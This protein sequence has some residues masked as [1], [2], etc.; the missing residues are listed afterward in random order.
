[1]RVMRTPMVLVGLALLPA[2]LGATGVIVSPDVNARGGEGGGGNPAPEGGS[3]G[4]PGAT[5]GGGSGG[6]D[7][8]GGTTGGN[9]G[10]AG[11]G[12]SQTGTGGMMTP[13][14]DAGPR[15]DAAPIVAR[16]CNDLP[17]VGLWHEISPPV[18]KNPSNMETLAVVVS[19]QDQSVYAAAGNKTSG[20]NSGTGVYKSMDCGATWKLVSTGKNSDKLKSGDP[21]AMMIHPDNPQILYTNNGYG[22]DPTIY[23]STNGGVDWTALIPDPARGVQSFVQAIA[24]N[25]DDPEHIAITFHD[26]CKAPLNGLCLSY[27]TD[28]GASWHLFNGPSALSG[29][30]EA[31]TLSILGPTNYFFAAKG[32]W[33]TADTGKTWTKVSGDDF[34]ASYAGSTNLAPDGTLYVAGANSLYSSRSNPIGS[35]IT[36]VTNGVHASVVINDGVN[37]FA[38]YAWDYGGQPYYTAKVSNPNVWT[39]MPSPKCGRGPNQMAIDTVHHIV[40]SANWGAGLWRLISR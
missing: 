21:W 34:T 36:K 4:A 5:G 27:S 26:N 18:F 25:P 17:A 23:K 13:P 29:W 2:C 39:H 3:G 38:S 19:Q 33:Y 10:S 9:H 6:Q 11:T 40:Y 35:T 31:A 24:M 16:P 32:G 12:G 15:P 20:G 28:G 22:N 7:G 14:P 37:L 1:M 30:I 8:T